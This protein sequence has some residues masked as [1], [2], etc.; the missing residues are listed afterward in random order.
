[1]EQRVESA[2]WS[3]LL[4]TMTTCV[5]WTQPGTPGSKIGPSQKDIVMFKSFLQNSEQQRNGGRHEQQSCADTSWFDT[6]CSWTFCWW[7][8]SIAAEGTCSPGKSSRCIISMWMQWVSFLMQWFTIDFDGPL[9]N[10]HEGLS[11]FY[12]FLQNQLQTLHFTAPKTNQQTGDVL[13]RVTGMWAPVWTCKVVKVNVHFIGKFIK[14]AS[15]CFNW[16]ISSI[17]SLKSSKG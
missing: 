13:Q 9:K 3:W 8:I 2:H 16:A 4:P 10:V 5:A 17:L 1:M 15:E 14:P 11:C 6:S 7:C 12:H